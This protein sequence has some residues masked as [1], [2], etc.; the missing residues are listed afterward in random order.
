M[1]ETTCASSLRVSNQRT[2]NEVETRQ[3]QVAKT[4]ILILAKT[5]IDNPCTSTR[6]TRPSQVAPKMHMSSKFKTE[7]YV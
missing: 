2:T 5:S 4:N 3:L 7:L 6:G 1:K